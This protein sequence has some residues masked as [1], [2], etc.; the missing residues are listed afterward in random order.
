MFHDIG[1][2]IVGDIP[3][4][5]KREN[6]KLKEQVDFLEQ[7]SQMMQLDYWNAFK[8]TLL[9]EDDKILIK[10][11]ELIEMAEFGL[12]QVCL[13]NQHGWIIADRC[14][15]AVYNDK[16]LPCASLIRYVTIRLQ[17]FSQQDRNFVKAPLEKWWDITSW[18]GLNDSK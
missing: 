4:P 11:I 17:L 5:V 2:T 1:E 12:E 14:L 7:K 13:G 18:E 15:K 16:V 3:F 10:Q 9:T 8:Q 6:S